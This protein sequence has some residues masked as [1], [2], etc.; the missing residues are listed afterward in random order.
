MDK[1]IKRINKKNITKNEIIKEEKNNYN[2]NSKK[3][4]LFFRLNCILYCE[5]KNKSYIHTVIRLFRFLFIYLE[6]IN[7]KT[8]KVIK[9]NNKKYYYSSRLLITDVEDFYLNTN[10]SDSTKLYYMRII[11]KYIKIINKNRKIRFKRPLHLLKK[12]NKIFNDD[13]RI[14]LQKIKDSNNNEF[15]CA[16]YVLYFLGLSTYQ[17]SKLK[18]KNL[19]KNKNI[20]RFIAYKYKKLIMKKKKIPKV[21]RQYFKKINSNNNN[22]GFLFFNKIKDEIGNTRKN[23]IEKIIFNYMKKKLKLSSLLINKFKKIINKER[24]KLR[25]SKI[26]KNYF[27]PFVHLLVHDLL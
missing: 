21:M 24:P 20:L 26:S 2:F 18:N 10:Y 5:K 8:I 25:L 19:S 22:S 23:K 7:S 15:L 9:R 13:T 4:D 17:L 1:L 16:Y 11:K 14:I 6:K 12:N 27:E 3:Y